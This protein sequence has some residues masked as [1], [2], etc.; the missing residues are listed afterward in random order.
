[1]RVLKKSFVRWR[2]AKISSLI[3][4]EVGRGLLLLIEKRARPA[5]HEMFLR[6]AV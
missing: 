4:A 6:L 3:E 2:V 5:P 1:V